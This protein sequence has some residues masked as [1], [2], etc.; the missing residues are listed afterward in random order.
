MVTILYARFDDY[1]RAYGIGQF[2]VLFAF[3]A[4][5]PFVNI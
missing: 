2:G 4:I 3:G 1:A 5:P